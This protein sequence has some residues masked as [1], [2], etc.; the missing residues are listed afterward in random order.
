MMLR[1]ILIIALALTAM[2]S[3]AAVADMHQNHQLGIEHLDFDHDK[4]EHADV[5]HDQTSS[6]S[7]LDCHH[8]CHCHPIHAAS[9]VSVLISTEFGVARAYADSYRSSRLTQR[10]YTLLRPPK[11]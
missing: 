10:H 9:M 5:I 6:E 3:V 8:C 1:S 4:N 7:P 11:V 2:Q